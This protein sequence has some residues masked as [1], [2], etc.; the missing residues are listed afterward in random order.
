MKEKD[1]EKLSAALDDFV[2]EK[3]STSGQKEIVEE[4]DST[5][6]DDELQNDSPKPKTIKI[7]SERDITYKEAP[8]PNF[9]SRFSCILHFKGKDYRKRQKLEV[10]KLENK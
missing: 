1:T 6:S 4:L 7:I 10:A 9:S 8:P 2:F 3:R 5:K